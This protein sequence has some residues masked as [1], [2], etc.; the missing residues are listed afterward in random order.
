MNGQFPDNLILS[1]DLLEGAYARAALVTDIDL[2]E[3]HPASY[4]VEASR[5]HRWI[6]GDWQVAKWLRAEVPLKSGSGPNPLTPLSR[7]KIFDNLRRSLV[8]PALL[9]LLLGGTL[10]A[11]GDLWMGL[12]VAVIFLPAIVGV[13]TDF[14]RQPRGRDWRTHLYLTRHAASHPLSQALL[15]LVLLPYDT[16]LC[17]DAIRVSGVRMVFTQRTLLLWQLPAYTR[18]NGNSSLLGYIREMWIAPL[19]A[20]VLA[21]SL[22]NHP[23]WLGWWGVVA[24]WGVSPLLGWSLSRQTGTPKM[25]LSAEQQIFLRTS[26]R[27]T[28]RYFAEF[29]NA[30]HHWLPPDNFQEYPIPV[31]A[32]RTSRLTSAWDYLPI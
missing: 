29:V 10:S 25:N 3:E 16:L 2:I 31:V 4:A 1:H 23:L 20:G 17:L 19:L 22:W 6:R 11:S 13:V 7:W 9:L 30:D 21:I 27:R 32:A 18:R 8:S 28:W 14:I 12:A 26:A 15:T 5:R 24:L